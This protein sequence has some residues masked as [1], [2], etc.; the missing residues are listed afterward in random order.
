MKSRCRMV[1]R[2]DRHFG[3]DSL[4]SA[5]HFGDREFREKLL[6]GMLPQ[7]HDHF[8]TDEGE[9]EFHPWQARSFLGWL[10]VAILG[11]SVFHDVRD[12]DIRTLEADGGE[13]LIQKLSGR[14]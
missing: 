10:R 9:L 7:R 1:D 2:K 3:R 12:I 5:V 4:R 11:W 14:A 8:L 6:Q 13:E